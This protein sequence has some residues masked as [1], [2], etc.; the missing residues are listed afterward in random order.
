MEYSRSGGNRKNFLWTY[1][2]F[3]KLILLLYGQK[4]LF[5]TQNQ[6]R[7]KVHDYKAF[8]K[9]FF[10]SFVKKLPVKKPQDFPVRV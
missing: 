4:K 1:N 7:D 3:L 6:N 10:K 5:D 9:I 8:F 2:L